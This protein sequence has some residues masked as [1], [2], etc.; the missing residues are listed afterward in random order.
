MGIVINGTHEVDSQG[1]TISIMSQNSSAV[2]ILGGGQITINNSNIVV[3]RLAQNSQG[4]FVGSGGGILSLNDSMLT[5]SS[6]SSDAAFANDVNAN[7]VINDSTIFTFGN[8][9]AAAK[10][11]NG[12][13]FNI[14]SS[15]LTTFSAGSAVLVSTL[16]SGQV[17]N[18]TVS[19]STLNSSSAPTISANGG[20]TNINFNTVKN[21]SGVNQFLVANSVPSTNTASIQVNLTASN[22]TLAGDTIIGRFNSANIMFLNNTTYTGAM[23]SPN[24][25][26]ALN[27]FLDPSV[28]NITNNSTVYNLSNGGSIVFVTPGS[29]NGSYKTLTVNGNYIGNNGS[30]TFNAILDA[31]MSLSD[32]LVLNGGHASG[33]T[34]VFINNLGGNGALT[35][36]NGI[37]IIDSLNGAT[38]TADAFSTGTNTIEAGPYIYTLYQGGIN[39]TDPNKWYLRSTFYDPNLPFLPIPPPLDSSEPPIKDR[40]APIDPTNTLQNGQTVNIFGLPQGYYPNFRPTVSL[41]TAIPS[42]GLLYSQMIIDTLHQRVGEQEQLIC[43]PDYAECPNVNGGWIRVATNHG[44]RINGTILQN[45]PDF[46]YKNSALQLGLDLYHDQTLQ[47]E[48]NFL[49]VFA[50]AG[51]SRATV[52]NVFCLDAGNINYN[53]YMGGV[54]FTHYYNGGYIDAIGQ[55]GHGS[56]STINCLSAVSIPLKT[57]GR[58]WAVSFEMGW[59]IELPCDFELEPQGQ[60]SYHFLALKS[61]S[62]INVDISFEHAKSALGRFGARL[63]RTICGNNYGLITGW[64]SAYALRD[65]DGEAHTLFSSSGGYIPVMSSLHG[66]SALAEAGFSAI[67]AENATLYA[68]YN[69]Q[70]FFNKHRSSNHAIRAGIRVNF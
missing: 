51:D 67:I 10:I 59:S 64:I 31:D 24:F 62:D 37:L 42:V 20:T 48:A 52:K 57:R 60:M 25:P 34:T 22:S 38:A 39:G 69:R 15:T 45:G 68:S 2:R 56:I 44:K 16:N 70:W 50:A 27:V 30:I 5:T 63:K 35:L 36:N 26:N 55:F 6:S 7:I 9:S 1:C 14:A 17:G 41:N 49:G 12:G 21:N 54:Y 43:S 23:N 18:F 4:L 61:A 29:L 65:F 33:I 46:K 32:V 11:G 40:A 19:N 66:N 3:S 28:W 58:N 13:N 53:N 47:G 8:N